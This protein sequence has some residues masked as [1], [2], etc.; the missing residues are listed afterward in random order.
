MMDIDGKDV[1]I[2]AFSSGLPR[3]KLYIL[4]TRIVYLDDTIPSLLS[5]H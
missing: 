4:L 2:A 5:C 3:P 1:E